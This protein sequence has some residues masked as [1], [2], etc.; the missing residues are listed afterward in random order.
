MGTLHV[1]TADDEEWVVAESAE[2]ACAVYCAHLGSEPDTSTDGDDAEWG[3]HPEHW[4]ELA[5]DHVMKWVEECQADAHREGVECPS[6]CD[7]GFV[8]RSTLTCAEHVAKNGRGYLG[9]SNN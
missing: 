4:T 5:D 3:T 1:W 6:K 9:S 7:D 2:D 8:I